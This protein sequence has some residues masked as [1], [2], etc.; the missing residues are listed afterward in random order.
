LIAFLRLVSLDISVVYQGIL[1]CQFFGDEFHEKCDIS[2]LIYI[3]NIYLQVRPGGFKP[4][5]EA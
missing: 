3:K 2:N 4:G 1:N 5:K